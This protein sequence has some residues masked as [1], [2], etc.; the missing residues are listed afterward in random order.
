MGLEPHRPAALF[1]A[2]EAP[3]P[4]A[5]GGALRSASLLEY[6][7]LRYE[8]DTIV[9]RQ[10]GAADPAALFP[11]GRVRRV[12]VIDLPANGHTE[13]VFDELPAGAR[14]S[15]VTMSSTSGDNGLTID[16][17]AYAVLVQ[18]KPAQW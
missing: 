12:T 18:R 13:L 2:P 7:T 11:P 17:T 1:L 10:P 8:V 9:F 6:L 15:S 14:W 16:D 5:G 4:I 3:Y